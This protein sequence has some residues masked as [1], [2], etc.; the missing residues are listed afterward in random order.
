MASRILYVQKNDCH[1]M[2]NHKLNILYCIFTQHVNDNFHTIPHNFS[3]TK[4]GINFIANTR[5]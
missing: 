5:F 2:E 4:T 3:T 1:M